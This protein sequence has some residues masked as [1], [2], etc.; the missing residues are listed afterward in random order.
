MHPSREDEPSHG[1]WAILDLDRIDREVGL[2]G[3]LSSPA[4]QQGHGLFETLRVEDGR[5]WFLDRHLRRL[6]DSAAAWGWDWDTSKIPDGAIEEVFGLAAIGQGI[7]RLK[8]ILLDLEA[9]RPYT[10]L[11]VRGEDPPADL[12]NGARAGVYPVR[13]HCPSSRTKTTS[14]ADSVEARRWAG[15]RGLDL[16]LFLSPDGHLLEEASANVLAWTG[17]LF[18]R[19][20]LDAPRLSGITEEV[21]AEIV[22]PDMGIAIEEADL[23]P[24]DLLAPNGGCVTSSMSGAVPL[25][26]VDEASCADTTSLCAQMRKGISAAAQRER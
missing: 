19:P 25:L 1:P 7:G 20:P 16:A 18:L 17:D 11:L 22:L 6:R 9:G 26:C 8:I 12:W 3:I 24:D 15:D 5:P 23:R 2:R 10:L 21:L 4:L 13:R 14:Y